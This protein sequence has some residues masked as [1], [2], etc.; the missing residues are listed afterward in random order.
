M[1]GA[2]RYSREQ[3]G[4]GVERGDGLAASQGQVKEAVPCTAVEVAAVP[5][6]ALV[7]AMA[8]TVTVP[9]NPA[10]DLATHFEPTLFN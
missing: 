3:S 1:F 7:E 10:K 9:D 4:E 6:A 5:V 8:V 2:A